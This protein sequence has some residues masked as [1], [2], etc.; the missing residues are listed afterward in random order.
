M[1]IELIKT[2]DNL[3]GTFTCYGLHGL[4][5]ILKARSHA[6]AAKRASKILSIALEF[7]IDTRN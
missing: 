1:N 3:D 7:T 5:I 4:R 2:H 6:Q